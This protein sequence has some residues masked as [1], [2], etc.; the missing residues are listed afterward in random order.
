MLIYISLI[1]SH[2]NLHTLWCSV[3]VVAG[4]ADIVM[5]ESLNIADSLYNLQLVLLFV[6]QH[7]ALPCL[8]MTLN[9]LFYA[10]ANL[11]PHMLAFVAELFQAFEIDSAKGTRHSPL[12]GDRTTVPAEGSPSALRKFRPPG[13]V[14][15]ATRRSFNNNGPAGGSTGRVASPPKTVPD[16]PRWVRSL[17]KRCFVMQCIV[18][19]GVQVIFC[20]DRS[21]GYVPQWAGC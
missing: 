1:H 5:K 17:W 13:G 7:L 15:S 2:A 21:I 16:R 8:H 14:S 18:G 3:P 9:D 4:F 19:N 20:V 6:D 11:K 10:P 12:A